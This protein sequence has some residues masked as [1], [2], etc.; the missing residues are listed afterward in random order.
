VTTLNVARHEVAAVGDTA[1]DASLLRAAGHAFYV[2]SDDPEGWRAPGIARTG[3]SQMS[4]ARSWGRMTGAAQLERIRAELAATRRHARTL[5]APLG[6]A[7][8]GTRPAPDEWSVAECV[9]H[10]NLT[11]RA[12][13]PLVRDAIA[14]GRRLS[15]LGPGPYRRDPVGW[16]VGLLTE[17]PIRLRI[18]TTAPFVPAAVE[19]K[20]ATLEA[21]DGLGAELSACV[22][23]A[24]GL[25]LARLRITSPFD[26]RLAYNLYACFRL[27][28]AHERLHL[29]QAERA[30]ATLLAA[31]GGVD[32]AR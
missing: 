12:F 3:T 21:F 27:I 25:D 11:A 14:R 6:E 18:K 30:L 24:A 15:L 32:R 23:D 8:W 28:P 5:A 17:P 29:S 13:L 31:G 19:P 16:F 9:I 20:A 26:T 22:G 7:L 2:G 4:H 10:L 1:R